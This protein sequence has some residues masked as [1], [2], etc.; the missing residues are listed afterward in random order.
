MIGT[1]PS[2]SPSPGRW[3]VSL[4]LSPLPPEGTVKWFNGEKGFGFI[5][6]DD[7]EG[8]RRS[9]LGYPGRRVQ[10]V[11]GGPAG[12]LRDQPGPEGAAGGQR[13]RRLTVAP[14]R[15]AS[16]RAARVLGWSRPRMRSRSVG[17][18]RA[19]APLL[20]GMP[21]RHVERIVTQRPPPKETATRP[22]A[23]TVA[24]TSSSGWLPQRPSRLD[25]QDAALNRCAMCSRLR[26]IRRGCGCPAPS[27]SGRRRCTA[28]ASCQCDSGRVRTA[29]GLSREWVRLAADRR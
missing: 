24:A 20:D 13:P 21:D 18:G 26:P 29:S 5:A 1:S 22:S 2:P 25:S 10:V 7:G 19:P 15:W 23:P 14:A 8:R 17:W 12:V 27:G 16:R 3:R 28:R 11:G 9:L 4:V 6:P